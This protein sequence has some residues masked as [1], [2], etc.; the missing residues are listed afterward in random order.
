MREREREELTCPRGYL[1]AD[2]SRFLS[3][4]GRGD[5]DEGQ[6]TYPGVMVRWADRIAAEMRDSSLFWQRMCRLR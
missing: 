6:M 5:G 3:E 1:A 2:A 4:E